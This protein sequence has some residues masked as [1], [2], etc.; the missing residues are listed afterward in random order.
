MPSD[1]HVLRE[2]LPL[3]K[4]ILVGGLVISTPIQMKARTRCFIGVFK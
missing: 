3:A 4:S 2:S 1:P